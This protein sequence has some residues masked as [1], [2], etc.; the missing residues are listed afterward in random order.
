MLSE[1][2]TEQDDFF[3]IRRFFFS[4]YKIVAEAAT[5]AALFYENRFVVAVNTIFI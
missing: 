4:K 5:A 3:S 1:K 2:S